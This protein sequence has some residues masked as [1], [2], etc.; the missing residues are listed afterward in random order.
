[1]TTENK[2]STRPDKTQPGIASLAGAGPDMLRAALWYAGRGLS[3]F[4]VHTPLFDHPL[5]HTCTCEEY[6]HTDLC[7]QRD[8]ERKSR[9]QKP[10]YLELGQYCDEPGKHPRGVMSWA[11]NSTTDPDTIRSWWRKY[12]IANIGIDCGKSGLLVLDADTYKYNFEG[13]KLLTQSDEQT[14]TILTGG[15]G[16]HLWYT[17]PEGK[18]W[19]NH[20]S[21]LP[22]GIDIRGVGGYV[23]AAPSLHKTGRRYAFEGGYELGTIELLPV[24]GWLAG[25]LDTAQQGASG[26]AGIERIRFTEPTTDW[27]NLTAFNLSEKTLHT[28]Y[29][30]PQTGKR[31]EADYSVCV[32][33]CYA[34]ATDDDILAVFQHYPVGVAGK[35]AERGVAYLERTVTSARGYVA[36]NPGPVQVRAAIPALREWV[37]TK[38]FAE[39][40]PL[41]LQAE[42]GYRTDS[43]DT[44]IAD[45]LLDV[46]E[47]RGTF[48]VILSP[49]DLALRAGL[50]SKNTADA[51]LDRM[52]GWFCDRGQDGMIHV[53]RRLTIDSHRGGGE[54][55]VNLRATYSAYKA[56]DVFLSGLSRTKRDEAKATA[57]KNGVQPCAQIVTQSRKV[58][59]DNLPYDGQ[60][61]IV[62][63]PYSPAEMVENGFDIRHV[64]PYQIVL[65]DVEKG[66]GETIL[67][68]VDALEG[69]GTATRRALASHTGKSAHTIGRACRRAE[70][71]GLLDS[72]REGG[73]YSAKGYSLAADWRSTCEELRP[74]LRTYQLGLGR[75][76]RTLE[77]RQHWYDLQLQRRDLAEDER[78]ALQRRREWAIAQR[79]AVGPILR[80][81]LT[82]QELYRLIVDPVA[83]MTPSKSVMDEHKTRQIES[84]M[85]GFSRLIDQKFVSKMGL[86]HL[87]TYAGRLGVLVADY[88]HEYSNGL[89]AYG[90]GT[91]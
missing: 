39:F 55:M 57:A 52:A 37:K 71:L 86:A 2:N 29:H 23:V 88:A 22:A 19:G 72:E 5:G 35:Y 36:N 6:R 25:V 82:K 75:T 65:R 63:N 4:P 45:A 56:D 74:N 8:D 17:M 68:I 41:E 24:P 34:G 91:Q 70:E 16:V 73:A 79:M 32:A 51:A 18:T 49:R 43:T 53:A 38:S 48:N 81:E 90:W 67:R 40:V 84:D 83:A 87:R 46:C 85:M 44:K 60:G 78:A 28:I 58:V 3:I 76:D 15:G 59:A 54:R 69:L 80:P 21:G 26:R 61:G 33:L 13:K 77:G 42:N 47:E 10:L 31:S 7:K 30:P 1:M 89:V 9:G 66:L 12:P 62:G 14:V 20:N 50:G 64:K 27:P 11:K